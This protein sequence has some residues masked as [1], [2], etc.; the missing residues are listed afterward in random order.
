MN[1]VDKSAAATKNATF[2]KFFSFVF[3]INS[4][5]YCFRIDSFANL[6]LISE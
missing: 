1:E 4:F 2:L 3:F 5:V 6:Y